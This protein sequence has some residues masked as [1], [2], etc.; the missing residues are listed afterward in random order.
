MTVYVLY[1]THEW[2]GMTHKF[3]IGIYEREEDARKAAPPMYWQIEKVDT[4]PPRS[5]RP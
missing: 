3:L 1:R 4:I 2:D 5:Q